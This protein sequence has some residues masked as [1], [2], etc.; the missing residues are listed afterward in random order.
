[1]GYYIGA[2]MLKGKAMY[3]AETYGAIV[4]EFYVPK[5]NFGPAWKSVRPILVSLMK[6]YDLVVVADNGDFEAAAYAFDENELDAFLADEKDLR[7]M[8][9]MI[10]PKGVAAKASGYTNETARTQA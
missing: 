2:P 3:L 1:M 5:K 7:P 8:L 9:T 4:V 6:D 10:F